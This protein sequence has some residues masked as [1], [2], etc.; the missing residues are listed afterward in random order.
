M[1]GQQAEGKMT[2][3]VNVIYTSQMGNVRQQRNRTLSHFKREKRSH[4][5][6]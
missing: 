2:Q 1:F 4:F 6:L 5:K 3:D